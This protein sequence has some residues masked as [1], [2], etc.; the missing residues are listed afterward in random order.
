M[1]SV[2]TERTMIRKNWLNV[3][4]FLPEDRWEQILIRLYEEFKANEF[5]HHEVRNKDDKRLVIDIRLFCV[6]DD[7]SELE[8]AV[9]RFMA[10]EN[11]SPKSFMF[12]PKQKGD[13]VF[14]RKANCGFI[15]AKTQTYKTWSESRVRCYHQ[16]SVCSVGV[17]KELLAFTN[18]E[19]RASVR[20]ESTHLACWMLGAVECVVYDAR[21]QECVFGYVDRTTD[22]F[23]PYGSLKRV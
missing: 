1:M 20:I 8:N 18:P 15:D 4:V 11:I 9:S 13:P 10:A 19:D 6:P 16:L 17:L 14:G 7:R 2:Q 21:N 5:L 3:V 22:N 12:D 23:V